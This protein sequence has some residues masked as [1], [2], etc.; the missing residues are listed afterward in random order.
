MVQELQ[1]MSGGLHPLNAVAFDRSGESLA[2]ASDD[3]EIK[4]FEVA[5]GQHVTSLK[6][7][8]ECVQSVAFDPMGKF[9]V[10]AGSDK[11]FRVWN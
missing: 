11:T 2:A 4:V 5:S 3:G 1:T 10:S 6:G 9:L 8:E 7:H